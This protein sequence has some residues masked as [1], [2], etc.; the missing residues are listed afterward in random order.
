MRLP[1]DLR[2]VNYTLK[3]AKR[4]ELASDIFGFSVSSFLFKLELLKFHL[5][6]DKALVN[7]I[8]FSGLRGCL[9]ASGNVT[10]HQVIQNF[11]GFPEIFLD[12]LKPHFSFRSI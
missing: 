6:W 9:V 11:Q 12:F 4:Y 2:N 8:S 10:H 3:T 1:C 5:F 7:T